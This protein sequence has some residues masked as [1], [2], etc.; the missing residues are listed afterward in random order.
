MMKYYVS[1][2]E[3]EIGA[4]EEVGKVVVINNSKEPRETDLYI[5]GVLREHLSM[6]PMEMRWVSI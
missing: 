4:F 5:S 1:N 2:V 6:E 3:T